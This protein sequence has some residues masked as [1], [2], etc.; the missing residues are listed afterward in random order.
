MQNRLSDPLIDDEHL[1]TEPFK[2]DTV[3]EYLQTGD[4]S[5]KHPLW[6][7]QQT[8]IIFSNE[9]LITSLSKLGIPAKSTRVTVVGGFTGQFA[10][11]LRSIGMNVVFSDPMEEWVRKASDQGFES[12]KHSAASLPRSILERTDIVATFECYYFLPSASE[13]ITCLRLLSTKQ[14]L[15]FAESKR[16][17]ASLRKDCRYGIKH[18]FHQFMAP[19]CVSRVSRSTSNLLLHHIWLEEPYRSI[20]EFDC[21]VASYLYS[22]PKSDHESILINSELV[23]QLNKKTDVPERT[24]LIALERLFHLHHG[25]LD[26]PDEFRMYFKSFKFTPDICTEIAKS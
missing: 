20:A 3:K 7:Y 5:G 24:I 6:H 12:F 11:S 26:D 9:E 15:L 18:S 16:T 14:G 25:W 1:E 17:H 22:Y 13:G 8:Q 10:S 23:K 21:N 2:E 4:T 19:Y